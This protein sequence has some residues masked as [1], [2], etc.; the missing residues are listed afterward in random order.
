MSELFFISVDDSNMETDA[1]WDDGNN[2]HLNAF[3]AENQDDELDDVMDDCMDDV[4]NYVGTNDSL[5]R[6][7]II[8]DSNKLFCDICEFSTKDQ[9]VL[10]HHKEWH[11]GNKFRCVRCDFAGIDVGA[12]KEHMKINCDDEKY[13]IKVDNIDPDKKILLCCALK[14]V[15]KSLS[16]TQMKAHVTEK[17]GIKEEVNEMKSGN[18]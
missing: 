7:N 16:L 6:E 18:F 3:K 12:V 10:D 15:F 11:D 5:K 9:R 17:H 14:C 8:K 2:T 13:L 1:I 4:V